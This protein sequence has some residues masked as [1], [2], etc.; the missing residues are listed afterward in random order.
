MNA[1]AYIH[2]HYDEKLT[3][4][5]LA[6]MARLS[7]SS[8]LR[9]FYQV[10]NDTPAA[11]ILKRRIEAAKELLKSTNLSEEAIGRKTGFYDLAHFIRIFT[12]EAG[13]TPGKYR[14]TKRVLK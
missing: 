5:A 3:I 14:R 4:A 13:I 7:R 11:Y 2:G 12:A 6:Q 8:F 1:L 10:C 9:R